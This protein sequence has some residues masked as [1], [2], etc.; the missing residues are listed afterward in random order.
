VEDGET[1]FERS[2]HQAVRWWF[3]SEGGA[4]ERFEELGRFCETYLK[5]AF[6]AQTLGLADADERPESFD[7]DGRQSLGCD[8][9]TLK[10]KVDEY[11]ALRK[12]RLPPHGAGE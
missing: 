11:V 3:E 9:T 6:V 10:R 4:P 7:R 12:N 8:L 1:P 2:L 5:S